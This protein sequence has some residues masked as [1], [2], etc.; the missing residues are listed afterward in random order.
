MLEV[1]YFRVPKGNFYFIWY[2]MAWKQYFLSYSFVWKYSWKQYYF[3]IVVITYSF[4]NS[5]IF[6]FQSEAADTVSGMTDALPPRTRERL[7]NATNHLVRNVASQLENYGEHFGNIALERL[8]AAHKRLNE[9][10][11]RYTTTRD[12]RK[13][14]T[15]NGSQNERLAHKV[16][17]LDIL[18]KDGDNN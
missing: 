9:I 2:Y 5:V 8:S 13:D 7:H 18:T 6:L 3:K 12:M 1:N 10:H 14:L 15:W 4:V 17:L 16:S 11:S